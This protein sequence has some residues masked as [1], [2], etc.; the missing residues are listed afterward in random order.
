VLGFAKPEEM[1]M[2]QRRAGE[3]EWLVDEC[4]G[5]RGVAFRFGAEI[6]LAE[7]QRAFGQHMQARFAVLQRE[8]GSQR[9]VP[10]DQKGE[11]AFQR[12]DIQGA[13]KPP[14]ER[15]MEG[16]CARLHLL[17]HPEVQLRRRQWQA[18]GARWRG[19]LWR[20]DTLPSDAALFELAA[21]RL[22]LGGAERCHSR[23]QRLDRISLGHGVRPARLRG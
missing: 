1:R 11:A 21:Q 4:L 6:G 16:R 18:I 8:A 17:L 10:R 7:R 15:D 2:D 3:V 12:G 22:P 14:G 20:R 13:A 19:L 9:L 5:S 23:A